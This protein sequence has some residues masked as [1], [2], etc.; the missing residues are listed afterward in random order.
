MQHKDYDIL[1]LTR[2]IAAYKE[3]NAGNNPMANLMRE[4]VAYLEGL[5]EDSIL[6]DDLAWG[7][8]STVEKRLPPM[9]NNTNQIEERDC[10]E[11][12]FARLAYISLDAL[13]AWVSDRH[14]TGQDESP[15]TI[16]DEIFGVDILF[17]ERMDFPQFQS[18]F[19]HFVLV[20]GGDD[21]TPGHALALDEDGVV[22]DPNPEVP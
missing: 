3:R 13:Y 9:D 15:I 8:A 21:R 20:I 5:D 12:I 1:V 4:R 18:G 22:H 14:E 17:R 11:A 6:L 19:R 16:L 2:T 10:K 7:L